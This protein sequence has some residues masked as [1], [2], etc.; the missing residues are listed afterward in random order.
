MP[1]KDILDSLPLPDDS[2][3]R[4]KEEALKRLKQK[5]EENPDG[6]TDADFLKGIDATFWFNQNRC[7]DD[8]WLDDEW[9]MEAL[10]F[11]NEPMPTDFDEIRSAWERFL[12]KTGTSLSCNDY[13]IMEAVFDWYYERSDDA[14]MAA[15][16]IAVYEYLFL[17]HEHMIKEQE[18]ENFA[19]S[20]V[21]YLV[22]LWRQL[23]NYSRAKHMIQWMEDQYFAGYIDHEDYL[24]LAKTWAEIIIEERGA[25]ITECERDLNRILKIAWDTISNRDRQIENHREEKLRLAEELARAKD[26]SYPEAARRR[27]EDKFGA[28][29]NRLHTDARRELELAETYTHP[30]YSEH[31][32]RVLPDALCQTVKIELLV[33]IFTPQGGEHSSFSGNQNPVLLLID[34]SKGKLPPADRER[35]RAA[36]QRAECRKRFLNRD[37]VEKLSLLLRHRNQAEHPEDNPPYSQTHHDELLREVWNNNWIVTFLGQLH[38]KS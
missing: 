27:L 34:Y 13:P 29:W 21:P 35:V 5:F 24:S 22:R 31:R 28:L 6:V 18:V 15:R 38:D 3:Q 17:S 11:T 16:A 30:P 32:P 37:N 20:Y 25:E 9:L 1:L 7:E 4:E 36:L 12:D 19:R 2:E 14:S 8:D 23:K 33:Q 10:T 26:E